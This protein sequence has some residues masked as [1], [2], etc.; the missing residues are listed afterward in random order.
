MKGKESSPKRAIATHL[1]TLGAMVKELKSNGRLA[2]VPVGHWSSRF[3]EGARVTI[4]CDDTIHRGT[5]L[6]LF[7]SGHT[8]NEKIDTQ[9]VSWEQLEVR[10]DE[11][12]N[13]LPALEKLGVRVGDFIAIDSQPE[14]LENGYINARHL[15]DKAGVATVLAM[16]KKVKESEVELPVDCQLLFTISEETGSGASAV[17]SDDIAE[18]ITVDNGTQAPGQ[19]SSEFGVTVAMAD[20]TGP[21]DYHLTHFLLKLCLENQIPYQRDIFKFYRC[22]SAS[23]VEAGHDTRTALVTFGLDSS[24]GYERTH[25]D[26]LLSI[27]KLL[28]IYLQ[29]ERPLFRAESK[30]LRKDLGGFPKTKTVTIPQMDEPQTTKRLM[31]F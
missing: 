2:I 18:M 9:P 5:I 3:A 20:S 16:A 25:I 23:A 27:G 14:V 7:A 13:D 21:F 1:D 15:D 11:V 26:S 17:L 28:G 6:P 24:H 10:V 22:D 31:Q 19:N 4:F 8:F 12:V 30:N 29:S